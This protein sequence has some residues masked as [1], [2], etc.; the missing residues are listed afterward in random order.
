MIQLILRLL[1]PH[2]PVSI[3]LIVFA[4]LGWGGLLNSCSSPEEPELDPEP[5]LV[6]P[7]GKAVTSYSS[8]IAVNWGDMALRVTAGTIGN[9]P[10][11]ASRAFGYIGLTMYETTVHGIADH[12]SLARQLS[13]LKKLPLPK[14][15][16]LYNWPLALNAGQ[17]F[18]LKT[19]YSHA[20]SPSRA[21]VDSLEMA[22][23][24][25]YSD[26]VSRDVVLRSVAF[27]RAVGS[28]IYEWSKS[29]GGHEGYKDPFPTD[30]RLPT[31]PGTW[32]A[33]TDGQVAI[34]RALH[35]RWG[36]NRTFAPANSKMPLPKSEVYSTNT[37][38]AYYK[39]YKA[40]YDR[41]KE[42]TQA[43][44]E[45]AIWWSDDPSQ[46]FTPP[47][48]SY[49]L[50]TIAVQT[51]N[52]NLAQAVETYART[53]MAIADAFICCFKAKYT[54]H[55]ERPSSFIRANIDRTWIPFWPEP[56]FPGFSSGHSTQGAAGATV[57]TDLY[58]DNVHFV[59]DSHVG[60]PKDT[61]RNIEFKARTFNSFWEAAE[62]SG[63]SRILG[64]IHT[65]Q[66]NETGLR[67]GK[68]IGENI[69]QIAWKKQ[70]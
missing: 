1:G 65:Q 61:I 69:N 35:P 24:Q 43:D 38:S 32:F 33:P 29:D 48:H 50:A 45:A 2:R 59:D 22:M 14:T 7:L 23:Q 15:D 16:S 41:S 27:G 46:T 67:E 49:K 54:Y 60:R 37:N 62:E 6:S 51:A 5:R 8:D 18:I 55:N 28:A 52:A 36:N 42:L 63:R 21:A 40:V 44:K 4:I 31:T 70:S 25:A 58:G 17:A 3:R 68:K 13:G 56:P 20:S 10:T 34:A 26:T 12:Q 64:G 19:I 57:L 11:Y 30:Y 53:G 66:D 47:G 39:M 9:T